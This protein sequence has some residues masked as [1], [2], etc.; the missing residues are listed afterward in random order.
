MTLYTRIGEAPAQRNGV[1][2][3]PWSSVASEYASVAVAGWKM[4]A[5]K[6]MKRIRS[7]CVG[8]PHQPPRAEIRVGVN[9][10]VRGQPGRLWPRDEN[11][12]CQ[13]PHQRER[14]LAPVCWPSPLAE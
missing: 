13:G 8:D 11:G 9:N 4:F 5:S 14:D 6:M 1:A 2:S 7:Q 12:Q 3:R 10:E